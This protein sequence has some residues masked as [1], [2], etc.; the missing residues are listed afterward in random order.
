MGCWLLVVI[1]IVITPIVLQALSKLGKFS[2][3]LCGDGG[4]CSSSRREE[5]FSQKQTTKSMSDQ[6]I[7][8]RR[9]SGNH[10]GE[11]DS[12]SSSQNNTTVD[13]T[14]DRNYEQ[15]VAT[16]KSKYILLL[17]IVIFLTGVIIL[18]TSNV[19]I[20]TWVPTNR[21]RKDAERKEEPIQ[22]L[23]NVS[24]VA[25]IESILQK[26]HMRVR[27]DYITEDAKVGLHSLAQTYALTYKLIR[28]L[29]N[30]QINVTLTFGSHLGA[31]RHHGVIPFEE[32]DVDLAVFSTDTS[33]IKRAIR[34]TLDTQQHLKLTFSET[35]FGFQIPSTKE[36]QTYID[37]WMFKNDASNQ[38]TCVGH[39]LPQKSCKTWYKNFHAKPPPIYRYNAWFPFR[40]ELFGTERVPIPA[41]NIPIESFHFDD[42]GPNF[43]NTTCGPDR[44][45]NEKIERW[46]KVDML[47]R[48]CKDKYNLHPFVFKKENGIEQLR[49]GSV[50]IHEVAGVSTLP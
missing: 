25:E 16:T 14:Y 46:V 50:V 33:K 39:Q 35:D 7:T 3:A 13:Y 26:E 41:T 32:K 22:M 49:Q 10:S 23:Q 36:F 6:M 47:E 43:W 8:R 4:V 31:L 18:F 30:Q 42:R 11:N 19:D 9:H 29:Q 40:T 12:Q 5:E 1:L 38:T 27:G 44:R 34:T 48:Q 17:R 45:W 15:E 20:S 24:T 37:V 28:E 21:L 2:L